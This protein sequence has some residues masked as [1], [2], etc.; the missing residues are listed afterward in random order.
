M[1]K[2]GSVLILALFVIVMVAI[3]KGKQGSCLRS[4]CPNGV[5]TLPL[6]VGPPEGFKPVNQEK[7][8][9]QVLPELI[10]LTSPDCPACR[11]LIPVLQELETQYDTLFSV[12]IIDVLQDREAEKLFGIFATPTLIFFNQEGEE[13]SR[14]EG[15]MDRDAILKRWESLG[16]SP[17]AEQQ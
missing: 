7:G 9:N 14:K 4:G 3:E 1:K 6:P 15:F 10:V 12:E 5:C 16:V 13:L 17:V 2:W 11:R 8:T